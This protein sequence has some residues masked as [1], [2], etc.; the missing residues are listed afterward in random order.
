MSKVLLAGA[1]GA[2]GTKLIGALAE[3]GHDVLALA[4]KAGDVRLDPYRAQIADVRVGDVRDAAS[5]DAVVAGADAIV[6]TVGLTKPLKHVSFEE[7][8]YAGNRNLLDAAGRAGVGRFSYVSSAGLERAAADGIP[9]MQAKLHF[10]EALRAGPVPWSISR[11]SG[12][13]WNYGVLLEM[14]RKH[15][16]VWL[17]GD[18]TARS[19]P[20]DE[21]DLADAIADRIDLDGE[22]YSVGGPTTYDYNEVSAL[23]F[24]VLDKPP[25]VHHL[26]DAP[27]RA[28]LAA[29]RE[30][31]K[32]Q[33][34]MAA[35]AHWAMTHDATADHIGTTALPGWLRE[36]R[37]REFGPL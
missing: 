13:F 26:P 37:D 9:V 33:Y 23:I 29:M 14:A 16:S 5:L 20:I 12:F 19:T 22:T 7:V 35:F 34:G 30:V 25:K 6:S 1:T 21:A 27:I 2:L 10:E 24:G 11:P 3:R 28:G 31:A 8:D 32:T 17:F 4:R 15:G 18:G 36:N